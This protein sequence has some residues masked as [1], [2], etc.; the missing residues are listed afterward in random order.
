AELPEDASDDQRREIHR[1]LSAAR[2]VLQQIAGRP[3][4]KRS[5]VK[6]RIE[7]TTGVT[8]QKKTVNLTPQ[9]ALAAQIRIQDRGIKIGRDITQEKLVGSI[10]QA[11]KDAKLSPKQVQ[12]IARRAKRVSLTPKTIEKF[13]A[14]VGKV[15][16][17]AEYTDTLSQARMSPKQVRKQRKSPK[18]RRRETH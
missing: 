16:S 8:K 17:D 10:E 5:E 1:E 13:D 14:R 7:E 6:T 2:H 3:S 18:P 11:A 9:Q 15:A 12:A 4:A